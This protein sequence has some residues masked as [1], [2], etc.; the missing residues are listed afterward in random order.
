[1]NLWL[2]GTSMS[3]RK[4]AAV[5]KPIRESDDVEREALEEWS[6]VLQERNKGRFDEYIGQH[7]AVVN[8]V[9]CSAAAWIRTCTAGV[10]LGVCRVH[11]WPGR[12]KWRRFCSGTSGTRTETYWFRAS[13]GSTRSMSCCSILKIA[14]PTEDEERP[15]ED[16]L[17]REGLVKRSTSERFGVFGQNEPHDDVGVGYDRGPVGTMGL[18]TGERTRRPVRSSSTVSTGSTTT[19]GRGGCSSA[20]SPTLSTRGS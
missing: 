7:V 1:M 12:S 18:D 3:E 19:M 6:W 8:K 13:S 10:S 2:A 14:S 20:G 16:L 15:V 4:Q 9:N 11:A 5:A 17:Q